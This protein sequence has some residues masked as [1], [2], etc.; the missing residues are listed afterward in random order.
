MP[1]NKKRLPVKKRGGSTKPEC[2][3]VIEE[4]D[5]FDDLAPRLLDLI[6]THPSETRIYVRVRNPRTSH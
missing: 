1:T 3:T 2:S 4:V 5:T 6:R